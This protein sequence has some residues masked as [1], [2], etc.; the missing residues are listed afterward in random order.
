MRSN[1][2]QTSPPAKGRRGAR[3]KHPRGIVLS[4]VLFAAVLAVFVIV[5]PKEP[6]K[7][8]SAN[9]SGTETDAAAS[10]GD[11]SLHITEAMSSNRT[12][13]PDE[14]G[15]FPDWIELTNEGDAPI[16][17]D[18]YGLSDRETK[19]AFVFPKMTLEPGGRVVVF[20]SDET[21]SEAGKPLHAK[22]K[23]SSVGDSVVLFGPDG[24]VMESIQIPAMDSDTSY[25]KTDEGFIITD[26]YT[27]GYENTQEGY[28]QFLA[29]SYLETGVLVINEIVA[30][31]VSVL[32][33]EDGDFPDWIE[34]YNT[35]SRTIDLSNYALS[36]DPASPLKFRFP[37][38]TVIEPHGYYVVY[39]SGKDREAVEGGWPHARF[40]L[41]SN[42]ET[43]VLSDI[44]GRLLDK[45]TYDLLEADTSWG[46]SPDGTGN[47]RTFRQPTPGLSNTQESA[48]IMDQRLIAANTSGLFITEVMSSNRTTS[49][50]GVQGKYDYIEIYNMGGQAVNLKDYGLSDNVKK[51]RK[52]RFPDIT[53]P[54]NGYVLVYC[55]KANLSLATDTVLYAN[56]NLNVGGETVVLSTPEGKVLDKIV[57]PPLYSDVS[58]GRT[59]GRYGLFYYSTPTP[60]EPNQ[61]GFEGFSEAP[62]FITRGGMNDRP[63]E[64]EIKV[65]EGASVY[66]TTDS[67]DPNQ[68]STLYEGPIPVSQTTVIRA[69]AYQPG[70]E[71]SQIETQTFFISTY[72]SMPV[73]SLVTDPDNVWNEETG[74]LADGPELN[75][76]EQKTPW[77]KATYW[78]KP[79]YSGYVEYYDTEGV[80]QISQGMNF[81]VM[82]Q[83]SLDMPQKSF[84]VRADAQF[85]VDA[86]NYAFFEDR[87]YTSYHAF[88]LRNGGQDGLYTRVLDGLQ[89]RLVEQSG[90]SVVTQ[91]WRPVIVYLNGEY[92]GHYNMRERVGAAMIAQHE[93]WANPDAIDILESDGTSSSQ[94]NQGSNKD[95]KDLV[96]YVKNHDLASDPEAL[97]YVLDRVDLDNMIDYFFFEMFFG[98]TDPG[99]IRFYKSDEEDG[100]WR[101][102]L[103][104]VDWGLYNSQAGGP[105][106]VLNEK[107]MG[108]FK[109]KSNVL[110]YNLLKVPEIEDQF[111]RRAGDVFQSVLTTDN[112]ISLLDEMTAE[113]AP[114]MDMHFDRWAAEMHPK[115]SFDQ[116]KNGPGAKSY[117][118]TRIAR[119]K[120][121]MKKRPNIFWGMVQ[122]YFQLSETK[123]TEYFGPRPEMPADAI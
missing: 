14:T 105:S 93:G 90:S 110:I 74:M 95:Y 98:N 10:T 56:F 4:I 113:I 45:V 86:F 40:K 39:A 115:I 9:V 44:Q 69:R 103:Y 30:S 94:V 65:P 13:Y 107:G 36:D 27:P 118:Q 111:L 91:A 85:G 50:P 109:I 61:G 68:Y 35:S 66:Y 101:Y 71:G 25:A 60:G 19:I 21:R 3:A 23:L 62:E 2:S 77:K 102:V 17:L 114:E 51:P 81:H 79:H 108:S 41:R 72:H 78:K 88:V 8:A 16:D 47:F 43:V 24:V 80:Q 70:L 89:A 20:A 49:L 22:F 6:T 52:W 67:S 87:P 120:N 55:E 46:R 37:Q 29:S 1:R 99:N 119:A 104:D 117:W 121:V 97:Q 34:I 48:L 57:T 42:G 31:N 5:A 96:E 18:G 73:V 123:M 100:K 53:I 122:E 82:G 58:Y 15:S 75:R 28:A 84:A 33:D 106:F 83:F 54:A 112:M 63:I 12:A 32:Q 38:G 76:E 26:M 116:P 7:V 59:L 64:V 92:W 11:P